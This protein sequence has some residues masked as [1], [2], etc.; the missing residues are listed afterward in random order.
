MLVTLFITVTKCQHNQLKTGRF[1]LVL[2]SSGYSQSWWGRQGS[3]S[4]GWLVTLHSESGRRK[5]DREMK[6]GALLASSFI[7]SPGP[8]PMDRC[9]PWTGSGFPF[10]VIL[11]T[12][13]E[14]CLF[15][16]SVRWTGKYH[17]QIYYF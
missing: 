7:F 1:I 13:T 16:E 12:C 9:H 15:L 5:R 8:W 2:S 3:R 14:V 17:S 10:S 6:A 11:Q 4:L